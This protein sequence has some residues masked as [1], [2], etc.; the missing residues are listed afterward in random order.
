MNNTVTIKINNS[1]AMKLLESLEAMN[2]IEILKRTVSKSKKV[3]VGEK[4][5]GCISAENEEAA[6]NEVKLMR[7]EWERDI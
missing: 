7:E 6:L 1:K 2:L 3:N 4:L 5:I